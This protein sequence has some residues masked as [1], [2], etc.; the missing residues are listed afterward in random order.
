V[1]ASCIKWLSANE[2]VVDIDLIIYDNEI[3]YGHLVIRPERKKT[4]ATKELYA[5]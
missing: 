1:V 3:V 4:K 5:R 2:T